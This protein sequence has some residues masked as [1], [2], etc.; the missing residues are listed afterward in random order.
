MSNH[1]NTLEVID[2][3][4]ANQVTQRAPVA[5]RQGVLAGCSAG[6]I[7]EGGAFGALPLIGPGGYEFVFLKLDVENFKKL[8]ATVAQNPNDV[9]AK[10][11]LTYARHKIGKDAERFIAANS[12]TKSPDLAKVV[13]QVREIAASVK[14]A[15]T[16]QQN[17]SSKSVVDSFSK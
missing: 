1:D 6:S 14:A 9:T 13:D 2:L 7:S 11:Q 10:Q 15:P 3:N 8:E 12:A 5:L 16:T 17:S 4:D